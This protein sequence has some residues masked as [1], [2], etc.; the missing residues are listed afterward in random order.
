[1]LKLQ[2]LQRVV[3]A[4][5]GEEPTVYHYKILTKILGNHRKYILPELHLKNKIVQYQIEQYLATSF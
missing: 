3:P 4:E 2:S 5:N 1:M